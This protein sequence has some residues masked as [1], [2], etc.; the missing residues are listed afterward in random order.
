MGICG[1]CGGTGYV[2]D[3]ACN[4]TGRVRGACSTCGGSGQV[5][6]NGDYVPCPNPEC[7][8]G[9]VPVEHWDC[10]GTGRFK[11]QLCNGTGQFP[12]P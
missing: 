8:Q 2:K 7:S 4:G 3:E 1:I 10:N 11:H 6:S 9:S 12:P 5:Y